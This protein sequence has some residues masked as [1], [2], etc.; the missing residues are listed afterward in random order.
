MAGKKN[1]TTS[2]HSIRKEL[3]TFRSAALA[4]VKRMNAALRKKGD[5]AL[6]KIEAQRERHYEKYFNSLLKKAEALETQ[7]ENELKKKTKSLREKVKKLERL[8]DTAAANTYLLEYKRKDLLLQSEELQNTNEEIQRKNKE[9]LA[10]K[11]Q[12]ANEIESLRKTHEEILEKKN[13]LEEKSDA[14]LDQAD[15]LEEAN[16]VITAMHQELG[17]QKDEILSK[18]TEL[19]NLNLEKNNLIGIVAHDLKSPLNQIKGLTSLIRMTS[20]TMDGETVN[21]LT[22]IEESRN[23]MSDMI[24][25]ILDIEAIESKKLNLVIQKIDLSDTL[26]TILR[27][28]EPEAENKQI[29]LHN[30]SRGP[31]Y[32][33]ADAGYI[34]QIFE[35][36][37]SNAIK[38]SPV[39]KNIFVALTCAN[40][41]VT[42]EV[43]DEGPGMTDDDKKKLFNKYQKLSAKPTANESST[44]LG[45]SIVKKFV[46]EMNGKIWCESE[47]GSGASF[48]VQFAQ[49]AH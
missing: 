12:I 38:F 20:P 10:Q 48:F 45:L 26:G 5:E 35:N 2:L 32:I 41:V 33:E 24:S 8:K 28:F 42:A 49:A 36:L 11:E 44:G 15:Y 13:E 1:K 34:N 22:L 4:T 40:G 23:R 16:K 19:L 43:K 31:A 7:F 47:A 9:L 27:R 3:K 21:F 39:E 30:K 18:N 29:K 14:L 6:L 37:L 46:E 25:K 17:K